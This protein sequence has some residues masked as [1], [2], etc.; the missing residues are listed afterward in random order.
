MAVESGFE[1]REWTDLVL[2]RGGGNHP[3]NTDRR[4]VGGSWPGNLLNLTRYEF[5]FESTKDTRNKVRPTALTEMNRVVTYGNR[6]R[7]ENLQSWPPGN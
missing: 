7:P 3:T 5:E 6:L 2:R 4:V 1:G